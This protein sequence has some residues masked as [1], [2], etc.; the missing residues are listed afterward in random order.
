M[1]R[2]RS[3]RRLKH[4]LI[5]SLAVACCALALGHSPPAPM[6]SGS[7]PAAPPGATQVAYVP[8]EVLV[9]FRPEASS[10]SRSG[11]HDALE[12]VVTGRIQAAGIDVV[13]SRVGVP[14]DVL[15]ERYLSSPLVEHAQPNYIH[16][17]TSSPNDPKF[18]Q[19]WALKNTGQT[20][21]CNPAGTFDVDIDAPEAWDFV[22]G[23][24]TVVVAVLDTG[25]NYNHPDLLGNIWSNP[26]DDCSNGI[27]NDGNGHIDDCR[28]WNFAVN[29]PVGT[30]DPMDDSGHGTHV[31]GIIGARGNNGIGTSGVVWRVKLMPVKVFDSNGNG[32]SFSVSSGI[33]YARDNG[34]KIINYSGSGQDDQ[35]IKDAITASPNV[36]YVSAAFSQT[37]AGKDQDLPCS[38]P[39]QCPYYPCNYT[40]ANIVCVTDTDQND[41]LDPLANWGATSVDLAAPGVNI[42]STALAG[43]TECVLNYDPVNQLACCK[44]TSMAVPHVSGAAALMLSLSPNLTVAQLKSKL[45]SSV[46]TVPALAGKVVSG[47]RLNLYKA[48]FAADV[49]PPTA[50]TNLDAHYSSAQSGVAL[51]WTAST[52]DLVVDH[53][54]VYRRANISTS[55]TLI[56]TPATPSFVD[57]TAVTNPVTA[58]LYIVRAVDASGNFSGYSNV[59]LATAI[60]YTDDPLVAGSSSIRAVHITQL[61]TAVNALRATTNLAAAVWTDDPLSVGVTVV[62]AVHINELRTAV[63]AARAVIHFSTG[64]YTDTIA[65]GVTIKAIHV[66]ELRDRTR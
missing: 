54:E 31:A 1:R 37:P 6:N 24:G 42:L 36:L 62:K 20:G 43:G 13:K 39:S 66:S 10:L 12:T 5:T 50:P 34:A 49:T 8:G 63:D 28:G 32:T 57:T 64:G 7:T 41:A 55:Y 25:V 52:D 40:L 61:R 23:S 18:A 60:A 53:Y 46:D 19:Q 3:T 59:D 16:H 26:I 38:P 45:L 11:L 29:Y 2:N 35:A 4:L 27:D 15:V 47:G 21:T 48:L 9:R 17:V 30:N 22:T 33:Y 58:Y 44:G 56:G 14:T 51:G 65:A